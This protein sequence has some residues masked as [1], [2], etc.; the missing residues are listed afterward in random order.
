MDLGLGDFGGHDGVVRRWM[1]VLLIVLLVVLVVMV[2]AA[3]AKDK[4]LV[5]VMLYD[6]PNG[7]AYL[8]VSDLLINNK[9]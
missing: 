3:T 9:T 1:P 8:I 5:A 6:G 2:P 7:P 4:P